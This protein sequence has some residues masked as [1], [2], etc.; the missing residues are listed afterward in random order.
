MSTAT[1]EAQDRAYEQMGVNKEA[2]SKFDELLKAR[3]SVKAGVSDKE[4]E[5]G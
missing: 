4:R 2:A 5:L 1:V 3:T